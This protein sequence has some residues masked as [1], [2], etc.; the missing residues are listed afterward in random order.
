MIIEIYTKDSNNNIRRILQ[1]KI[2]M[3]TKICWVVTE[4]EVSMG[5][6]HLHRP[7]GKDNFHVTLCDKFGNNETTDVYEYRQKVGI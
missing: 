4:H 3:A 7:V 5:L 6:G 2:E 1:G